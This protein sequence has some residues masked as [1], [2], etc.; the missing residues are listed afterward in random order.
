M[1]ESHANFTL[2]RKSIRV[3]VVCLCL[4]KQ[5][6]GP[7]SAEMWNIV[8]RRSTY[9]SW[10]FLFPFLHFVRCYATGV[11]SSKHG[12]IPILR[13]GDIVI[14][15]TF[16]RTKVL[17]GR[18]LHYNGFRAG[19]APGASVIL[20]VAILFE[21]GQAYIALKPVALPGRQTVR[22]A[23]LY[24]YRHMLMVSS[25]R[26]RKK[27]VQHVLAGVPSSTSSAHMLL[28]SIKSFSVLHLW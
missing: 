1:V 21:N 13:P 17:R 20:Q 5:P 6:V 23:S 10:L 3:H 14:G 27:V 15:N 26:C 2:K 7:C 4:P 11:A 12:H 25:I 22:V 19:L 24:Q 18:K 16:Q 9:V 8:F 28:R